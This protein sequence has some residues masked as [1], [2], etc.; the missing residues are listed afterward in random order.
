MLADRAVIVT[1]AASGIGLATA[2][3]IATSGA[4][5]TAM[6]RAGDDLMLAVDSIK[7]SGGRIRGRVG[8]VRDLQTMVEIT[9]EIVDAE[10]RIDAYVGCAGLA[11]SSTVHEGDPS[12][13]FDV[14]GVNALGPMV[15][16]RATLP[17][18]LRQGSGDILIVTSASGR[19]T[20]VGEPAYIASKHAAIAFL[21][22]LRKEV[23]GSDVRVTSIEPGLVDTP[24]SRAH[25]FVESVLKDVDPLQPSDIAQLIVYCLQLPAHVNIN[26]LVVRPTRQAL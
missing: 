12:R 2:Q 9:T 4:H 18:M 24:M 5:V 1:G 7:S 20:Y 19:I 3:L 14:L 6:D 15:G 22:S 25:P 26:E 21:D 16:A 11:D 13:W 17:H 23:A 8:D 10:G